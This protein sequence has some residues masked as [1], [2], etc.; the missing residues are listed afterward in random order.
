MHEIWLEDKEN[1]IGSG[2]DIKKSSS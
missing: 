1:T 2:C